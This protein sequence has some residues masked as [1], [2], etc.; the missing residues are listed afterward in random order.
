[1]T[2]DVLLLEAHPGD[3][4]A[5]ALHL[6]AA[7][8][9]LHRCFDDPG[10]IGSVHP[11]GWAPCRALTSGT[12][13]LD[14]TIDVA[15]LARRGVVPRPA[16]REAG[17][18]CAVRAGVPIVEDGGDLCDPFARWVTR[19]TDT[20]GVVAA[21]EAAAV[22]ALT[23][24]IDRLRGSSSDLLASVGVDPTE[25]DATFDIDGDQL[26]IHLTGPPLPAPVGR[27]LCDRAHTATRDGARRF[28]RIDIGYSPDAG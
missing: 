17:V 3:G 28:R 2:L 5:D 4:T 11:S 19:R 15:L 22:S 13:A 10:H 27:A 16:P 26:V 14:E 24:I 20:A 23:P 12:C 7:G 9:R 18:R 8:H 1:M 25:I 21:C 6:T